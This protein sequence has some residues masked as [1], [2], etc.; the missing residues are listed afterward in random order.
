MLSGKAPFPSLTSASVSMLSSWS[1]FFFC[2]QDTTWPRLCQEVSIADPG[3]VNDLPA[4][5]LRVVIAGRSTATKLLQDI[6]RQQFESVHFLSMAGSL[7]E[8]EYSIM[9]YCL[10]IVIMSPGSALY[11]TELVSHDGDWKVVV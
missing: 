5:I 7:D 10:M 2:R 11:A 4:Y 3:Q 6:G 1:D 8:R 9:F